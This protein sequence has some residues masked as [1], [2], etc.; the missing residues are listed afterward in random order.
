MERYHQ[1][2]QSGE[3]EAEA[4]TTDLNSFCCRFDDQ[5]YSEMTEGRV[6]I[7][8]R[9]TAYRPHTGGGNSVKQRVGGNKR[10]AHLSLQPYM[11]YRFRVYA[12][13]E[14][15][16]S[17]TSKP[18]ELHSTP[19]EAP[20]NNPENVRSES[21]DPDSLVIIWQEMDRRSFNGPDFQYRVLWR[22]VL[23]SGP[24][25]HT[26]LTNKPPFIVNDIGNF[27]AFEMKVQAVNQ[28]GEGPEPDPV[29]GYSGE[30]VPLEAPIDVG[31]MLQNSTAIRVTWA[32]VDKEKVRG[33]LL[34]YKIHVTRLGS[35]GHHRGRRAR[36]PETTLVVVTGANEE[37][38]VISG[39]RPYSRYTLT[40]VVFNSKGYGPP[41]EPLSFQT[42]EGAP[43][44][45][46]S[47]LLDSPAETEITLHW[48]PPAQPN[49]ILIGYLLQYQQITE[50]ND[51]PVQV[52]QMD[53]PTTT[54][55][56]LKGLDRHSPYR[57]YLRGRTGAGDGETIMREGATTLDG[58]PPANFSLSVGEKSVNFSWVTKER[59]RNVGFQIQY[60][61]K[62]GGD[63]W[64]QSEKVNSTQSFYELQGLSPGSSYRFRVTFSNATLWEANI[65]TEG[66]EVKEVAA[67]FATQGWFIGLVSAIVLLLL[68]LLI[69]CFI[70][71]SKGGKYSVKDK[72]EGPMDSEARPMKDETFGEYRS[73][74]SD[75]ELKCGDSQPSLCDESKL[76]SED[77][78]DYNGSSAV[79]TELNIDESLASQY[80]R[81]SEVQEPLQGLPDSSHLTPT[82]LSQT[83]N[84]LPNSVAI[85]D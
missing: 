50:S 83:N 69:L 6:I 75:N 40:V 45:P 19:A 17:D 70:K 62:N 55:L 52:E 35:R 28:K 59:H 27:S 58:V 33:H 77:N 78:L 66:T 43:G 9:G 65:Q 81:P 48:T 16:V 67:G 53:D 51:S 11:S 71:R 18:T 29:I 34:G 49:G 60:L 57:F 46:M 32:A 39:L 20:D 36:E 82:L 56:T 13:N 64:K 44:P 76:C 84:G 14:V 41:S 54:H 30:D 37:E 63:K 26:S 61:K 79:T 74:E 47:L 2:P 7:Y 8:G 85:L 68:L 5:D 3:E 72:E 22:R 12:I 24:S 4:F 38:R 1:E 31:V 42:D 21:R 23:G 80:S 15:G 10:S 25:W 73:L